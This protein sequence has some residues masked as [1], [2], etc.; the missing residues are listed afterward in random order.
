MLET[1][2]AFG[3]SIPENY[4]RLHVPLIFEGFGADIAQRATS[5]SPNSALEIAAGTGGVTGEV[6]N[7]LGIR[8]GA[9]FA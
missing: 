6:L 7:L 4:D 2:K 9:S 8:R 3:G 5:L 1:N